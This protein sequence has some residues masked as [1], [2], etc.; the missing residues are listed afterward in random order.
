MF[1]WNTSAPVRPPGV[2]NNG[3]GHATVA[4]LDHIVYTTIP[5]FPPIQIPVGYKLKLVSEGIRYRLSDGGET[6]TLKAQPTASTSTI[7]G[8]AEAHVTYKSEIIVPQITLTGRTLVNDG[9]GFK[10]KFLAGQQVKAAVSCGDLSF[11]TNGIQWNLP[12]N[13]FREYLQV[14]A[15]PLQL[16]TSAQLK[17]EIVAFALPAINESGIVECEAKI[18][19]PP[20]ATCTSNPIVVNIRSSVLNCV[21]PTG[22]YKTWTGQVRYFDEALDRFGLY[23]GGGVSNGQLWNTIAFTF[24][25]GFN[26]EGKACFIQLVTPRRRYIYS[27]PI[28]AFRLMLYGLE[29]LDSGFPYPY[30]TSNGIWNLPNSGAFGYDNPWQPRLFN[31]PPYWERTEASDSFKTFLMFK[32]VV[33]PGFASYFVPV[34]TH[35]WSWGANSQAPLSGNLLNVNTPTNVASTAYDAMPT[36]D[37]KIVSGTLIYVQE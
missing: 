24:P 10:Y 26:E 28:R 37:R 32:P 9:S 2:A 25:G 5:V 20:A 16:H 23:P 22:S 33:V 36:W 34:A 1:A 31:V 21:K 30:A 11:E 4:E 13:A 6:V 35:V 15:G 7:V 18:T 12:E 19:C 8:P 14:D 27:Q 17:A 29:C 3:L